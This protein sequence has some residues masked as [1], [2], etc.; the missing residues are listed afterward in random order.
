MCDFSFC[1][2]GNEIHTLIITLSSI[3]DAG[4]TEKTYNTRKQSNGSL[5]DLQGTDGTNY[6]TRKKKR[7]ITI[8]TSWKREFC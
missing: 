6:V 2:K 3:V 7:K 4:A 8:Y 1:L 5:D